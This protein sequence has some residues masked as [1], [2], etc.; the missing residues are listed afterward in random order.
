M[1]IISAVKEWLKR[2]LSRSDIKSI[3]SVEPAITDTMLSAIE[4]WDRMYSGRAD[5]TDRKK[6]IHSLRLEQAVT[7]EFANI[8]LNEM[9]VKISDK[10]LDRLFKEA[11][12]T[13]NS[14]FQRGLSTGAMIIKPLGKEKV[15][16]IPQSAFIPVEYDVNG[17]LTKVIFPEIKKVS[18]QEYF[19]RLEYHSLD[20]VKGLTITNRVFRS[21][22]GNSL[23]KEVSLKAVSDWANL[24][25]KVSYPLM[26]RNAFG[27]YVNPFDNTVDY[28]FAGVSVFDSAKDLIRL[29]DTQFGRLDWE[30]ESGERAVDVEEIALKPA[31]DPITNAYKFDTPQIR[32]RLFR[33]LNITGNDFYHEFS[34]QLRQADFIAGLEEYKRN[35]EFV[36]GLSYGDISN[37]QTVDK[38]A[39]EIKASKARKYN[40]VSAIQNNLRT[41]LD[42]FV[43]S[44]AFYNALT[45]SGYEFICDFRDS[46]LTDEDTERQRDM[47]DV[48]AGIMRPEEYRAKWYGETLETALKNLPQSAQVLD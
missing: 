41:C 21:A 35:I 3:Y 7:R 13:L 29:T 6:G 14:N 16:Y 38:T 20:S 30:F 15:Q 32:E 25:P 34:P 33:S 4:C 8:A 45:T 47:Q 12:T 27:Y 44:L 36:V 1:G 19:I 46:I 42:D 24:S 18:E 39:T 11:M 31:V 40:T 37:P 10:K 23:G 5:W 9:T 26:F 2:M 17:R 43:Y 22:D 48:S 28:S